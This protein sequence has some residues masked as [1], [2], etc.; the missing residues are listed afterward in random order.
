MN[1]CQQNRN[2]LVIQLLYCFTTSSSRKGI[3]SWSFGG[4]EIPPD[5]TTVEQ[6]TYKLANCAFGTSIKFTATARFIFDRTC[7]CGGSI[8]SLIIHQH[9]SFNFS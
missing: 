9:M 1:R 6:S 5:S 3:C 8:F 2:R 7:A 4:Q